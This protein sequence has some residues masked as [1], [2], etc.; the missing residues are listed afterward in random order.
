MDI[1]FKNPAVRGILIRLSFGSDSLC[2]LWKYL[3][4]NK[5][6]IPYLDLMPIL[7]SLEVEGLI[8]PLG[9]VGYACTDAGLKASEQYA[10]EQ[11]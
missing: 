11:K 8:E 4:A 1:D 9:Y 3:N 10:G 6:A 2:G 7:N 5:V